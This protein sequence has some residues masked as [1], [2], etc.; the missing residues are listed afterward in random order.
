MQFHFFL[1]LTLSMKTNYF[2]ISEQGKRDY[3][4]DYLYANGESH[5]FIVCDGVGGSNR[6]DIASKK[7]CEYFSESLSAQD[8]LSEVEMEDALSETERKFDAYISE[9][10]EAQGM[11]TT[12]TILKFQED[13]AIAGHIGDSRIYHIRNGEILF[14]TQDHS[15][16]NELVASGFLTEEEAMIHPKKNQ[17]T[18]AIQGTENPTFIDVNWIES[19]EE[20]DYFLLC[21]DGILE[22][23]DENWIE[24]N[25]IDENDLET[26][27]VGV[28]AKCNENSKDNYTAIIIKITEI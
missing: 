14:K 17:I 25:F 23:I 5:L 7:A 22:G 27:E 4:E 19:I 6:G 15:F 12:L 13:G 20:K 26:I 21:S 1:L 10:P 9:F 11:A 24:E 28:R 8:E 16:V 18:R 3:N 2:Q